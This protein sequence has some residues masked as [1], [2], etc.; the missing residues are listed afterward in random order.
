MPTLPQ[1]QE[2]I[3]ARLAELRTQIRSL[4]SARAALRGN[5]EIRIPSSAT[6]GRPRKRRRAATT[7][8]KQTDVL[9]AGKLL[10]SGHGRASRWRLVTDEERIAE[11][12]AEL[13]QRMASTAR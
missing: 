7:S 4:E 8:A 10:S 11:R 1:I 9:L 2:S 6:P 3:D 13:E 12:A 5:D